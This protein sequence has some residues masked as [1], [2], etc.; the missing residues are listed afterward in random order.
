MKITSNQNLVKAIENQDGILDRNLPVYIRDYTVTVATRHMAKAAVLWSTVSFIPSYVD[1][2]R[3]LNIHLA[4]S[5]LAPL[6]PF[7]T[8]LEDLTFIFDFSSFLS[9]LRERFEITIDGPLEGNISFGSDTSSFNAYRYVSYM[10]RDYS[11]QLYLTLKNLDFVTSTYPMT[12]YLNISIRDDVDDPAV[13]PT[14]FPILVSDNIYRMPENTSRGQGVTVVMLLLC[15]CPDEL[16][17]LQL[18][19][20]DINNPDAFNPTAEIEYLLARQGITLPED[21]FNFTFTPAADFLPS[22][23]EPIPW[24]DSILMVHMVYELQSLYSNVPD[25]SVIILYDYLPNPYN[26]EY[27]T[28][29]KNNVSRYDIAALSQSINLLADWDESA[30]D[31]A[32]EFYNDALHFLYLNRKPI[33]ICSFNEGTNAR[34]TFPEHGY[35]FVITNPDSITSGS[36]ALTPESNYN[37]DGPYKGSFYSNGGYCNRV[38]KPSD[39]FDIVYGSQ[40]GSP[41]LAGYFGSYFFC[42]TYGY[43]EQAAGSSFT[44]QPLAALFAKIYLNSQKRNW[45]FKFILQRKGL[46]LFSYLSRGVNVGTSLDTQY[47]CAEF[48][49]W[50]PVVGLGNLMY[51]AFYEI[52]NV[53]KNNTYVQVSNFGLNNQLSFLNIMPQNTFNDFI[54]RQPVFG[55]SSIFSF[56]KIYRD[57]SGSGT[58]PKDDNPLLTGM[59]IY[60]VDITERYALSYAYDETN[61]LYILLQDFNYGSSF[62]QWRIQNAES[63]SVV[64]FLYAFDQITLSPKESSGSYLSSLWNANGSMRPS[65]PSI[66]GGGVGI[67][68]IF[69]FNTDPTVRDALPNILQTLSDDTY[70]YSY[71]VNFTYLLPDDKLVFLSNPSFLS[72]KPPDDDPNALYFARDEAHSG[73]LTPR[74]GRFEE[75]PQWILIPLNIPYSSTM[76]VNSAYLIFNTVNLSYLFLDAQNNTIFMKPISASLTDE[77]AF[78]QFIFNIDQFGVSGDLFYPKEAVKPGLPPSVSFNLAR[79]ATTVYTKQMTSEPYNGNYSYYAWDKPYVDGQE[80]EVIVKETLPDA[81]EEYIVIYWVFK[82]Y[83]VDYTRVCRIVAYNDLTTAQEYNGYVVSANPGQFNQ[84]NHAPSMDPRVDSTGAIWQFTSDTY[85]VDEYTNPLA[86]ESRYIFIDENLRQM[87]QTNL[88]AISL[89]SSP[90]VPDQAIG[91]YG[92]YPQ[93]KMLPYNFSTFPNAVYWSVSTINKFSKPPNK[94]ERSNYFYVGTTYT[95]Y[96]FNEDPKGGFLSSGRVGGIPGWAP[97]TYHTPSTSNPYILG[98][99]NTIFTIF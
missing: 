43:L 91:V 18:S 11:Q 41:D 28:W 93:P 98:N 29:L 51:D 31:D 58:P 33:I 65:C 42:S 72:I 95:L 10:Y 99:A 59:N 24:R 80:L 6:G 46:T 57:V 38:S 26:P 78:T 12:I 4:L 60:L 19:T 25:A 54:F 17:T 22:T 56:F 68:E 97:S 90:G 23:D 88:R 73:E 14:L 81:S 62:Q 2:K 45:D 8:N 96:S 44:P 20:I 21:G 84:Q 75:Y 71:Y 30:F 36:F 50:N 5:V 1:R 86:P 48:Y 61:H 67:S 82:R 77:I 49:Y 7:T 85:V 15:C 69:C 55:F 83:I 47:Y 89:L 66:K 63:P 94:V 16:K 37:I 64:S 3:I 35:N 53:M 32:Q 76:H 52:C 9:F 27:I 74:W 92:N 40:Y 34:I 87:S 13:Y 79:S 70:T 39:Q